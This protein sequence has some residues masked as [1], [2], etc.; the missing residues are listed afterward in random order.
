MEMHRVRRRAL[1]LLEEYK[2][3]PLG[4]AAVQ[5]IFTDGGWDGKSHPSTEVCHWMLWKLG[6]RD[7]RILS[8]NVPEARI[9]RGDSAFQRLH[10]GAQ[11]LGAWQNFVL[12]NAPKPGDIVLSGSRQRG[13]QERAR[14][15]I[16]ADGPR[17][18]RVMDAWTDAK[19]RLVLSR[20]TVEVR[21]ETLVRPGGRELLAGWVDV[22][23]VLGDDLG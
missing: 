15:F 19:D 4:E 12:D 22:L 10:Q 14:I 2:D 11:R 5:E 1:G 6:C 18:W 7:S 17:A 3:G 13:E 9:A 23:L 8:R 21:G 20:S 16:A